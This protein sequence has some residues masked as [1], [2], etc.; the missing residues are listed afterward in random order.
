MNYQQI[1]T[2]TSRTCWAFYY[3]TI[4]ELLKQSKV[5]FRRND[6]VVLGL[7]IMSKAKEKNVKWVKKEELVQVNDFPESFTSEMQQIVINYFS[8][9]TKK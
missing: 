2:P 4:N 3:M 7:Q 6:A 1:I 8:S 9:K 5:V